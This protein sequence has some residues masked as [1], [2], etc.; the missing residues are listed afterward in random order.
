[1]RTLRLASAVEVATHGQANPG[2]RVDPADC[3]AVVAELET[4]TLGDAKSIEE[5]MRKLKNKKLPN[6]F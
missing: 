2:E 4:K 5:V 1:M 6:V 3:R